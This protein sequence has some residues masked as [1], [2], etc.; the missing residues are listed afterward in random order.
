MRDNRER[1]QDVLEAIERIERY[2]SRGRA[3]FELVHDYFSTDL[4][5][6][7]QAVQKDLPALKRSVREMLDPGS[8]S[9]DS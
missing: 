4:E 5:I 3:A 9:S 1:L 8:H 6:V 7:W 2:T